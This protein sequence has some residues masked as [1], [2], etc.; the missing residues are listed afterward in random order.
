M[1]GPLRHLCTK[2]ASVTRLRPV[3]G[4]DLPRF[5]ADYTPSR[6]QPRNTA[7]VTGHPSRPHGFAQWIAVKRR[8]F[9]GLP[10]RRPLRR[11]DLP[12][13]EDRNQAVINI[14]P[15][16]ER[17]A[18]RQG[19]PNSASSKRHDCSSAMGIMTVATC[20][21]TNR[22][23]RKSSLWLCRPHRAENASNFRLQF[24]FLGFHVP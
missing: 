3:S 17:I 14:P 1:P 5:T 21:Q 2:F 16:C 22:K 18:Q 19:Q 11:L 8:H 6:Q 15:K 7:R 20:L 24:L 10:P 4:P 9:E 12:N 13:R 23:W